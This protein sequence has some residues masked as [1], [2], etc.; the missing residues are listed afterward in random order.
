M[1]PLLAPRRKPLTPSLPR[2]RRGR[3]PLLER[4]E[5]RALLSGAGSLDPSF[6]TGGIVNTADH[7]TTVSVQPDGKILTVGWTVDRNRTKLALAR[8]NSSGQLDPSF[9]NGGR[10]SSTALTE[11]E[12]AVVYPNAG[13]GLDGKIVAVDFWFNLAR[14][15]PN[16]SL[17]TSFGK[18]GVA[19]TTLPSGTWYPASVDLVLQPRGKIVA[20]GSLSA[21]SGS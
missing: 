4:L 3:R 12:D 16:G 14:Y 9:G 19:T 1:P 17:D 7:P 8:Y 15:N 13:T 21:R 6:G 20:A 11:A 18:R 10:V 5:G 2:Q